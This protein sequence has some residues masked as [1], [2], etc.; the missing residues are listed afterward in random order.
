MNRG[1]KHKLSRM[2]MNE[3]TEYE[4]KSHIFRK[5][6]VRGHIAKLYADKVENWIHYKKAL[7]SPGNF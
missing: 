6:N 7:L 1:R 4:N 5:S 3:Y 2:C